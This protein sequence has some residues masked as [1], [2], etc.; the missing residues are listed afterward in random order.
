MILA[1]DTGV[2][3]PE[4]GILYRDKYLDAAQD[5]LAYN[6]GLLEMQTDPS[7]V[8]RKTG[9]SASLG[10]VDL[11]E[12]ALTS[13][14]AVITLP[15]DLAAATAKSLGDTALPSDP[16]M[17]AAYLK[18]PDINAKYVGEAIDVLTQKY[19]GDITAA[20]IAMAPG[21]DQALV[22]KW[23]SSKHDESVLPKAVKD[24]YRSTMNSSKAP[25]GLVHIGVQAEPGV[26]I[27]DVDPNLLDRWEKFQSAFGDQLVVISG[28]RDPNHNK[29]VGGVSQS[30][31]LDGGAIDI[32]ATG[33][34]EEDKLR[35]IRT[36]SAMGFGGIGVYENSFHLDLGKPRYWG[37][38]NG[39]APAWAT[40][41]LDQHKAGAIAEVPTAVANIDPSYQRLSFDMRSKLYNQAKQEYDR[42]AI[43]SRA[44]IEVA[45]DNAPAAIFNTGSYDGFMPSAEDFVGAYGGAAG[46]AKY[47]EFKTAVDIAKDGFSMR[48][49]SITDISDM[50]EAKAPTSSGDDASYEA[51]RYNALVEAA[52]ATQK[53]R[54]ADPAGYTMEAFPAVKAKFER[55]GESPEE[56]AAAI[57]AMSLAQD[58]LG[59]EKKAILP[60]AAVDKTM[61]TFNDATQPPEARLGALSAAVFATDQP[62]Q[63][64]TILQQLKAA[65]VPAYIDPVF[66]AM[67]RGDETGTAYLTRA[68]LTDPKDLPQDLG[69]KQSEI[70]EGVSSIFGDGEMGQVFYGT[71]GSPSDANL[72]RA[73]SDAI[74]FERAV[75]LRLADGSAKNVDEAVRLTATDMWGDKKVATRAGSG[76]SA[77]MQITIPTAEDPSEFQ[78][79]FTMLM[80]Q[81]SQALHDQL[82]PLIASM[83]KEETA[84]AIANRDNEI[85]MALREGHFANAGD[86]LYQFLDMDGIAIVGMDGKPLTFTTAE[87]KAAAKTADHGAATLARTRANWGGNGMTPKD[88]Y[89]TIGGQR[90][91]TR[92][93]FR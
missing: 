58:M 42:K 3:T 26:L 68:L 81:I 48:T 6:T 34:T 64:K 63:R 79:G 20:V 84:R 7:A 24:F 21:A 1:L 29:E 59:I 67:E 74:L 75:K 16:E 35:F 44:G 83:P 70:S 52:A 43:E 28:K 50:L 91:L 9:I 78:L 39:P 49:M 33:M 22:S 71:N 46:I 32:D 51:K 76:T 13:A 85:R 56:S 14:G 54:D 27:E 45:A 92:D 15:P 55:F 19:D 87:V 57:S 77:G 2:I 86:G 31:H 8:M 72:Q 69:A 80:P 5:N 60:K 73:M 23:I 30:E 62:D 61:A 36:A 89:D 37:K 17:Q 18:D 66:S 65:G 41:V 93:P 47:K 25:L 38:N 4:Q 10:G 82:T 12:A 53:A 11:G 88:Y 90:Q 40:E